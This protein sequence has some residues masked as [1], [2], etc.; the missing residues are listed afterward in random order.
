MIFYLLVLGFVSFVQCVLQKVLIPDES[1]VHYGARC[2]DGSNPGY[3]I[4]T[5]TTQPTKWVIYIQGGGLCT[6][7]Q[8]CA[9]RAKTSLGTSTVWPKTA[10]DVSNVL[11][12]NGSYNPFFDFNHVQIRYCSGDTHT[13]RQFQPNEWGLYFAGHNNF[14]AIIDH[15]FNT[16]NLRDATDILFSGGSAGGIGCF[17]HVNYLVQRIHNAGMFRTR[18][19]AAPKAGV[20]FPANITTFDSFKT[21]NTSPQNSNLSLQL[22]TLY[23]SYVDIVCEQAV[24]TANRHICWDVSVSYQYSQAPIFIAENLFDK[25]QIYGALGCQ[26]GAPAEQ[27]F[28]DFFGNQML[29]TLRALAPIKPGDGVFA[30][31]C[32]LHGDN[33]CMRSATTVRGE[34]Y[35]AMLADWFAGTSR[36]PHRAVDTCSNPITPCNK[37]C[38]SDCKGGDE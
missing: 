18:L 36:I 22:V 32:V 5:S 20:Y 35:A 17:A 15:L 6:T 27:A 10:V 9:A 11:S 26:A 8:Q 38:V 28:I 2:L 16:T 33:L 25:Q 23:D 37:N 31:A 19:M 34:T 14:V 24:G 7:Q 3:F 13:G 1:V 30:P 21:G 4:E 29:T 12:T